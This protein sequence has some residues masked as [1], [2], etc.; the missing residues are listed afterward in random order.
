MKNF[1]INSLL[2]TFSLIKIP[3]LGFMR[4]RVIELSKQR[5][6]VRVKLGYVTRNHLGSMYFGALAM[7]AELSIGVKIFEK[8]QVDK[9]PV[10]FIFK[11][12]DCRFHRRA[13]TAIDFCFLQPE[14]VDELVEKA[15]QTGERVEARFEGFAVEKGKD[16]NSIADDE[17][18]MS[19]GLTLSVKKSKER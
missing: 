5:S 7:G 15:V 2:Q 9:A 12:F 1:K 18:I 19:Y 6:I 17:K 13:E 14:G 3:L 8:I 4:P 16:P 11:D 10:N